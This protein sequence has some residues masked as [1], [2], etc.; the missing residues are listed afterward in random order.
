MPL[1]TVILP[2]YLA[3]AQD[4]F[5][6]EQILIP[7]GFPTVTVPLNRQ[8]WWV[9]LGGR[10]VTPILEIL[11]KT[12]RSVLHETK[13]EQVNLIGHSA[14]GWIAR[15]YLGE[16]VYCGRTWSGHPLVKTL[17]TLGT[18]HT[19]QERWSRRNIDFVDRSYPGAFFPE[20]EYVSIAG[21]A[22]YGKPS[23]RLRE[24]FTYKSYQ[25]TCGQGNCWGDGVIPIES[26]HLDGA[27]NLI[28]ENVQHSPRTAQAS[29]LHQWYGSPKVVSQWVEHLR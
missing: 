22:L 18:P 26:A 28:L 21:K 12:I 4:Y 15:I 2:G 25:L 14:G 6:L 8:N 23:W 9:T 1:P 13:A 19:S 5:A 20:I 10:P 27:K 29:T 24:W 17:L 3:P 16:K 11:D 7:Q